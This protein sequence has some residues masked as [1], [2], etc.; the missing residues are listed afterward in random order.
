MKK[1]YGI[2]W[3]WGKD[4]LYVAVVVPY[5]EGS[6]EV[7]Y[8][9]YR[10]LIRYFL[11]PKFTGAGGALIVNPEAGECF[12]LDYG[13]KKK[14]I[15]VAL[16]EAA[17]KVPVFSGVCHVTTEGTVKE[18]VMAKELGVDGI[19]FIPPIGSGD[20]TYAWNPELY[21][22]VWIDMMKAI[23]GATDLP[24]IVH[25]TAGVSMKYGVGL[26]EG[27]AVK[28]CTEVPHI[29]GWK[30]TYSYTGWKLVSEALRA[31]DHHVGILGAP[32]DLYHWALLSGYFDGSVNGA[33]CYAME[34]MIG[35]IKAWRE[36][37]LAEARRIWE[38][39]LKQLQDFVY[40]DY[41]RLHIRYKIGAW[42]RGLVPHPFMRPP[43]PKP[44]V[45]ECK[46]MAGL[47]RNLHLETISDR[48][49]EKVTA[50]LPR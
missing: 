27:P 26:P 6:F 12:Y 48:E 25:P 7:D 37:N 1:S 22:E 23:T 21:P 45:F 18:A 49:I 11:Q 41:S 16:E 13:E 42:L 32:G 19:F 34:P 17:G 33:Y 44:M 39:G 14:I 46:E 36:N 20:I 15:E 28:I 9:A 24:M 43:Q 47:L 38:G 35:H 31:L 40:G 8:A 50:V 30:M 2:N 4:Y 5:R 3:K 29:I 10:Q